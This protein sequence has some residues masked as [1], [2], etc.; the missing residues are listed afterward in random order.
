MGRLQEVKAFLGT[1]VSDVDQRLESVSSV[2]E[3]LFTLIVGKENERGAN[4]IRVLRR[5]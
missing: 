4:Q 3:F 1:L 5:T 2:S